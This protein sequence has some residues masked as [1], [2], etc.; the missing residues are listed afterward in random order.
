MNPT[1]LITGGAG[2]IGSHTALYLA[3]QGYNVLVLDT[4]KHNQKLPANFVITEKVVDK[5]FFKNNP[6]KIVVIKKDFADQK[7]L[8]TI[9]TR[10]TIEAVL[11]FAAFIEVGESVKHPLKFYKNN[12]IKT[13]HLLESM[14]NH[15]VQN[16]VF[17]SSC[18]VYGIPKEV[19]IPED[20]PKDPISPYGKNKLMVEMALEDLSQ[21][22]DLNFVSLRYFNAAGAMPQYGLGEQ[23]DPETHLIPLLLQAAHTGKPFYIFGT[24]HETQDGTCIRDYLHVWDLADA[25]AKAVAYLLDKNKSDYFNLGTG[26]GYSVH[27]LIKAVEQVCGKKIKTVETEKRAG[28]PPVLIADASKAQ[29][30]LNWKPQHSDLK[31]IIATA[32]EFFQRN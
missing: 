28:D 1:I 20:H 29:K 3:Q 24:N 6:G 19:P 23:H 21:A 15:N 17:S 13:L 32:D 8:D 10:F 16:F 25:H 2:Y 9:F 30:V 4:L 14:V 27:D 22:H 12:V 5:D 31:H 18:A 26:T 11:H 7:I